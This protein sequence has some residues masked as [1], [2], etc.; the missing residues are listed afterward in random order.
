PS[1]LTLSTAPTHAQPAADAAAQQQ[2]NVK[3]AHLAELR[4]QITALDQSNGRMLEQIRAS[5]SLRMRIEAFA[6]RSQPVSREWSEEE[7]WSGVLEKEVK[8]EG[9]WR[10]VRPFEEYDGPESGE[11]GPMQSEQRDFFL[12]TKGEDPFAKPWPVVAPPPP[13]QKVFSMPVKSSLRQPT[14]AS[15]NRSIAR[16]ANPSPPSLA[17]PASQG[18]LHDFDRTFEDPSFEDDEDNEVRPLRLFGDTPNVGRTTRASAPASVG[19]RQSIGDDDPFVDSPCPA[20]TAA[21][22]AGPSGRQRVGRNLRREGTVRSDPTPIFTPTH[23][24]FGDSHPIP[25]E[26][27]DTNP[28]LAGPSNGQPLQLFSERPKRKRDEDAPTVNTETRTQDPRKRPRVSNAVP[29]F[30]LPN[31]PLL[32]LAA[33][34]NIPIARSADAGTPHRRSRLLPVESTTTTTTTTT[35]ASLVLPLQP[36]PSP[37]CTRIPMGEVVNAVVALAV[38]VFIFRWATSSKGEPSEEVQA[39]RALRFRPK[40]VTP[41]MQAACSRSAQ[42]ETISNMFPDIPRENIHYDLLRT[43]SVEVTSNKIIERG[44]LDAVRLLSPVSARSTL[45]AAHPSTCAQPP[46]AYHTLYPRSAAPTPAPGVPPRPVSSSATKKPASL[47]SRFHLESRV[48]SEDTTK[49][50]EDA[51]GRAVWEDTP[52]KRE[53]SLRERKAQMVLA[54][55]QRMLAQQQQK[56]GSG[57]AE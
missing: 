4:Q 15:A 30:P 39:A 13:Y 57:K 17:P 54:A 2:Q 25:L 9:V 37:A 26:R 31:A 7:I 3:L 42:T 24:T 32:E 6:F 46:Q 35:V 27:E 5:K 44:F 53:A 47:I 16:P 45:H 55:R 34:L 1:H 29:P 28:F 12:E 20:P 10:E 40:K 41:E 38:I 22:A 11:L 33:T 23:P 36:P 51:G 19:R 48:S 52:E 50:I 14:N 21:N 18:R 56:A 8:R 43:G 49:V